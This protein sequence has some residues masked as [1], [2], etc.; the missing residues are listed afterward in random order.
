MASK[1]LV[2]IDGSVGS[3][4]AVQYLVDRKAMLGDAKIHLLNVQLPIRADETAS[5]TIRDEIQRMQDQ[6]GSAALA[7]ARQL[8]ERAGMSCDSAVRVGE[9]AEAIAQFAKERGCESIVMG[10]RGLGSIK[11]LVLGSVATKVIH[12]TD[13]PVTLVK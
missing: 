2:P 13:V 12:L 9:A 4:H 3:T 11:S 7:P 6:A 5:S 8:L 10:T 1:V